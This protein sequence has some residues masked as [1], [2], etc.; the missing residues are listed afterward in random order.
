MPIVDKNRLVASIFDGE[1]PVKAVYLGTQLVWTPRKV[2]RLL[3]A[4]NS[5]DVLSNIRGVTT[6]FGASTQWVVP[7]NIG[8]IRGFVI[9]N[10]GAKGQNG[11]KG[12]D[13]FRDERYVSGTRK[14][15]Y[16]CNKQQSY[17]CSYD[18]NYDCSTTKQERYT[19]SE[20]Y[21]C[22]YNQN[23]DCSYNENY[24]CSTTKEESYTVRV[25][26]DCSRP[27][28][29]DC[30]YNENY[31]CSYNQDYDCSYNE[32]YDCSY[33]VIDQCGC[34]RQSYC[35][36]PTSRIIEYDC[37]NVE[38]CGGC[39][40]P[41]CASGSTRKGGCS[42]TSSRGTRTSGWRCCNTRRSCKTRTVTGCNRWASRQVGCTT[43]RRTV[44]RTCQ[45]RVSKT[46]QRRVSKTCQ[47]RISRTCTRRVP[48]TCYRDERRTRNVRVPRTC[49]RRVPKT[50]SRRVS[51]TCQ[52][53]VQRTREVR[54]PKT[55]TR[56]VAKTCQRTVSTTC[57]RTVDVYST[58]TVTDVR[59]G[60]GGQ[61]GSGGHGFIE[62]F[63]KTVSQHDE[64]LI[65]FLSNG[66][67]KL[68]LPTFFEFIAEKGGTGGT[69]GT[70]G[71]GSSAGGNGS[72][73]PNV[74]DDDGTIYF[75]GAG[76]R[77]VGNRGGEGGIGA[78]GVR[79]SNQRGYQRTPGVLPV[80]NSFVTAGTGYSAPSLFN[81]AGRGQTSSQSVTN[82]LIYIL[83][84]TS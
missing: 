52:R 34:R 38:N 9:G 8:R 61:G 56:R 35:A 36:E 41:S 70:G 28:P 72:D 21:D 31:D 49:S 64:L 74:T 54:V 12:A 57:S 58:R 23:Y 32:N 29:Y 24:D 27:E 75:G 13:T 60:A 6:Q 68:E 65:R 37:Q 53:D 81:Q 42:Y 44:P 55:C 2:I 11:T 22:S 15:N 39:G 33:I 40:R 3:F 14:E 59:G 43:C 19:V 4:K 30:S 83:A 71:R 67:V 5:S 51:R 47:R 77:N 10:G 62:I 50:C 16:R 1:T 66:N 63:D 18:E 46:C 73:A 82:G 48:R 76:K 20:D 25:P 80:P 79:I 84:T 26:Y 17:D 78:S 45:R 7:E 69:G